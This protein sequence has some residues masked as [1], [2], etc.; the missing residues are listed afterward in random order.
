[1]KIVL[2]SFKIRSLFGVKD[3]IPQGLRSLVVYKFTC[4]SCGACYV[5]ETFRYLSTR[6]NEHLKTDKASHLY[7]H[8]M[9]SEGG[10]QKCTP[11]CFSI[12]DKSTNISQLKIKEAFHI[13]WEKPS[14]NQQLELHVNLKLL[15]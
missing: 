4:S 5:E 10:R 2:S 8:L 13:F 9:S 7:K 3:S 6:I 12:I 1:M 11:D 14:L 15:L